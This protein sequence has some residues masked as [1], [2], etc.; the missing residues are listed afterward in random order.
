MTE[1]G[2][3]FTTGTVQRKLLGQMAIKRASLGGPS[4]LLADPLLI[5][6]F[7]AVQIS[8]ISDVD[9]TSSVPVLVMQECSMQKEAGGSRRG[10]V[11]VLAVCDSGLA[12]PS[13]L[14]QNLEL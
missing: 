11:T 8:H 9:Q 13:Y 5:A 4:V 7:S 12:G 14:N 10:S 6:C 1:V 2:K 3:C